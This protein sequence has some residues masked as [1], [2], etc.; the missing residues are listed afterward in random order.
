[1]RLK[2]R[3]N[4]LRRWQLKKAIKEGRC[5]HEGQRIC[6]QRGFHSWFHHSQDLMSG[7]DYPLGFNGGDL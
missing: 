5:Q 6:L 2:D 1:M 3:M 4:L 7:G